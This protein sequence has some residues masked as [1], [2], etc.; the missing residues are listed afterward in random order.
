MSISTPT[1][2]RVLVIDDNSDAA[3]MLCDLVAILGHD[4]RYALDGPAGIA[5]AEAFK[6]DVIFLDIGMPGMNGFEVCIAL[7]ALAVLERTCIVALTAWTDAATRL[8]C[9]QCGFHF[10]LAKPASIDLIE[11]IVVQAAAARR[12]N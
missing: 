6:P 11:S 2:Q 12:L 10:H 9:Q 5:Q 7:R 1:P 3:H 4:T 8:K